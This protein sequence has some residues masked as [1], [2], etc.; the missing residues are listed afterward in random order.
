MTRTKEG[1]TVQIAGWEPNFPTE[2][3]DRIWRETLEV[4]GEPTTCTSIFETDWR[5]LEQSMLAGDFEVCRDVARRCAL[6]EVVILK[7]AFSLEDRDLLL[8]SAAELE[9]SE[10]SSFHKMLEGVPDYW[11]NITEDVGVK[12]A[13]PVV[14]RSYYWFPWN[15]HAVWDVVYPKWRVL[16]ALGGRDPQHA[17]DC[18]PR[19]G[20][21]DRI[22]LVRYPIGSGYLAAH[23][24][25]KHNQRLIMSSYFSKQGT[26]YRTGGF[27]VRMND[28]SDL[29]L[30]SMIEV[31]DIGI[32]YADVVHGVSRVEGF[33]DEA[34]ER[35]QSGRW[36]LGM[37]LNDSDEIV[38]RRTSSEIKS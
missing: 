23:Q 31:G 28:G 6:G 13:V 30:E 3:V 10:E 36:W 4:H 35:V 8:K 18:T 20:K 17:E 32:C 1:G 26:D 38:N 14:K 12:Y 16:K 7:G 34:D 5:D 27:W 25:P 22:Q 33:D 11:R 29:E 21:C 37:F 19:D 24:D 15:R 2:D 9:Q